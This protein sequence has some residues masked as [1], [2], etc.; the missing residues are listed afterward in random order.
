MLEHLKFPTTKVTKKK[1][2]KLRKGFLYLKYQLRMAVP[3]AQ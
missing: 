1:R 3:T 2:Y